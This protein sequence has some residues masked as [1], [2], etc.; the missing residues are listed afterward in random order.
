MALEYAIPAEIGLDSDR[1]AEAAKLL[2][3]W[4]T[5]KGGQAPVPGGAILVG[6]KGRI[7]EPQF[8]GRQ[9]P[10]AGAEAIRRDG[11]FL[12]ASI[13]KPITYLAAMI[14]VERGQ[15]NLSD[16][17]M[18]YLP[19]FAADHKEETLVLHLF[20]HTSGLPDML[21]DNAELRSQ[22]AP[23]D[24][25]IKKAQDL[26]PLFPP[27]TGRSY[28]SMGTLIVAKLIQKI[29]GK[30]IAQFLHDELFEPL[31]M[32]SS[33]LGSKGLDRKRLVRVETPEYQAGSDF[34]WNSPY[35]QE[36]GAP[37]GGMFA[38]PEDLAII[39]QLML[40][41]GTLGEE[42]IVSPATVE[43]MTTNQLVFQPEVPELERRAHPWGLG[44]SLNHR[45]TSRS[46]GALLGPRTFGHTGAT[47]TMC[48]M[49]PDRDG[50]CVLLTSAIR[51]R[52]PWRL[53]HLSNMV[54][55]AFR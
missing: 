27:G 22:H 17:V 44:W 21:P 54:A 19:D 7:V 2:D 36:F 31:K 35:W 15:L 43:S 37:W 41:G 3:D 51:S 40:N 53:V 12:L 1:L 24:V 13:T 25:F 49:D 30:S 33:G 38:S 47:G 11:M 23:L 34:G 26:V 52:A 45:G 39:C 6:R 29:S 14:L 50:F 16:P 48:W 10:E 42:R 8:F 18:R 28:Q 5:P 4:T 20:T 55:S 9:G 32:S 46:W